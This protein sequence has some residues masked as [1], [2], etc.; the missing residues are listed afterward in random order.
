MQRISTLVHSILLAISTQAG[1]PPVDQ[2]K[3]APTVS[4]ICT[5]GKPDVYPGRLEN[6]VT[7]TLYLDGPYVGDSE[8]PV[9]EAY[10]QRYSI[11]TINISGEGRAGSILIVSGKELA[12]SRASLDDQIRD[13]CAPWINA[14]FR[15]FRFAFDDDLHRAAIAETKRRELLEQNRVARIAAEQAARDL[16]MKM[17]LPPDLDELNGYFKANWNDL[18]SSF[19]GAMQGAKFGRVHDSRCARASAI[20]NFTC[21]IG[22]TAESER[23]PEYEKAQLNCSR[24]NKGDVTCYQPEII[25]TWQPTTQRTPKQPRA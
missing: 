5:V 2:P 25:V 9:S 3:S 16:K 8:P 18:Q 6:G 23:G 20:G 15:V 11:G 24:S 7:T 10:R 19:P 1:P 13:I 14:P 17:R 4:P 22:V 12:K 21:E